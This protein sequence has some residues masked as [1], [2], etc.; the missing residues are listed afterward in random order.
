[1]ELITELGALPEVASDDINSDD[2]LRVQVQRGFVSI[3]QTL[4]H[5][6]QKVDHV[7]MSKHC[8][9]ISES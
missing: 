2:V 6:L 1:M 3:C 9:F 4:I 7:H 5:L 8:S